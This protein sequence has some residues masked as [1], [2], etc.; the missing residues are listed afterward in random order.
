MILTTNQNQSGLLSMPRMAKLNHKEFFYG[1]NCETKVILLQEKAANI[2]IILLMLKNLTGSTFET[3]L[4]D[5]TVKEIIEIINTLEN[6]TYAG[7]DNISNVFIKKIQKVYSA[8]IR[9]LAD[10]AEP[11]IFIIN[12]SFRCG[13]FPSALKVGVIKPLF[14]KGDG[15]HV[16]NFRPV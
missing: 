1:V 5:V 15:L 12:E 9:L 6:K 7:E 2:I 8:E 10:I 14:K 4:G 13:Y 3:F 11:L 16:E